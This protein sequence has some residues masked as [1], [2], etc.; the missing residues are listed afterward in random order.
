M[1]LLIFAIIFTIVLVA[2]ASLTRDRNQT[3]ADAPSNATGPRVSFDRLFSGYTETDRLD[4]L[5]MCQKRMDMSPE[6]A[7]NL[8]I[9][10]PGLLT[11]MLE[12]ARFEEETKRTD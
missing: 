4:A 9:R 10:K 11:E 8:L 5:R 7:M 6:E 2:G 3:P 1:T 12:Y